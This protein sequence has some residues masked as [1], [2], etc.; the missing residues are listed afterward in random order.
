M[1]LTPLDIHHKEFRTSRFG[2]YNEEEVDSF[3]DLVADEFERLTQEASE[4][5]Q[6]IEHMKQRLSE[7]E[8]M[9]SVLQNALLAATKSAEMLKEQARGESE[10]IRIKAKDEA[11]SLIEGARDQ[12]KDIMLRAEDKTRK[13]EDEIARLKEIKSNYVQGL[14]ELAESHLIQVDEIQNLV[15]NEMQPADESEPVINEEPPLHM[16][17]QEETPVNNV[18]ANPELRIAEP[19]PQQ[20]EEL[21]VPPTLENSSGPSLDMRVVEPSA[22][23]SAVEQSS[24]IEKQRFYSGTRVK[25]KLMDPEAVATEG[26]RIDSTVEVIQSSSDLIEEVLPVKDRERLYA[27]FGDIEGEFTEGNLERGQEGRKGRRGKREKHFFWE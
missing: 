3:L 18:A 4:L 17:T 14:K 2:G 16:T 5:R 9:Q 12:A 20:I 10:E 6:Q 26:N 15:I 25:S 21:S 13:L 24:G 27:E 8:E 22:D 7:F 23:S 19:L 11:D 1:A